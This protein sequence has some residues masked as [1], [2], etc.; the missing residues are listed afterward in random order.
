MKIGFDVDGVFADF[1]SSFINRVI[2]V[3][4]RDLFPPRPFDIPTWNYPEA[5]GY[6]NK[7]VNAAWENI[8][9]DKAFWFM[10][11]AYHDTTTTLKDIGSNTNN[12]DI[13]FITSRPGVL[14]KAQ[15]E[16]WLQFNSQSH[17]EF[18][19]VLISS[20]KGLCADAL[21]LDA[22]IDDRWEN[23]QDVRIERKE[24]CADGTEICKTKVYLLDR[25]WNQGKSHKHITR[26]K[27]VGEF[28]ESIHAY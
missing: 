14:A 6:S 11:P 13:Y 25:P 18:P 5:Y 26:V 27:T 8:K 7:E 24:Q 23:C 20:E 2:K 1:N 16:D 28:W 4:G 22:Y 12:N 15:T 17:I 3:T 19:T 10:L 9:A 21:D